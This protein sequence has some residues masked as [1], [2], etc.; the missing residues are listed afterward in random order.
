[1]RRVTQKNPVCFSIVS[2]KICAKKNFE[3]SEIKLVPPQIVALFFIIYSSVWD[4][5]WK[6]IAQKKTKKKRDLTSCRQIIPSVK[7][8]KRGSL[9]KKSRQANISVFRTRLKLS[10]FVHIPKGYIQHL[11][12]HFNCPIPQEHHR[13]AKRIFCVHAQ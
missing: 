11:W 10:G 3:D 4:P 9:Q 13:G 12:L 6:I 2:Q 7:V 8:T 5:L 1:M